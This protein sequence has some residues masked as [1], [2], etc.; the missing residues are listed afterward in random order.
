MKIRIIDI[1]KI[2]GFKIGNAENIDKGTGCTVVICEDG[3]VGGVDVR[4]GGPAT[5]ETD[6]LKSENTIN[7]IN[8]VVLS[9]GSAFGLESGSGVMRELANRGIG[10]DTGYGKVPIV[11]GASLFD[12]S[13]GDGSV[14]PDLE[15]GR[16]AVKNA[17]EGKFE[18]GNRGAGTGASVGKFLG[19]ERAMKSGLGTFACG[20]KYVQV[21]A[22]VAVNAMGDIYNGAGNIVAGL[23]TEEGD[24]VYGSIKS[25]KS[26]VHN[27]N[28]TEETAD[29]IADSGLSKDT[30]SY[31]KAEIADAIRS[32][33]S[34]RIKDAAKTV[35]Q[36]V[37][38]RDISEDDGNEPDNIE[39]ITEFYTSDM[40]VTGEYSKEEIKEAQIANRDEND[41]KTDDISSE[42]A[43]NVNLDDLEVDSKSDTEI[44]INDD[45]MGYDISFNTTIACLITNAKMTKSQANKLASILHDAYA[46]AIK[47]VHGTMD[48]DT[49]FVLTTNKAEVNFDAF[50]ALSTDVLQYAIIDSAS[51]SKSAYGLP[52]AC[53]I[54]KK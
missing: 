33:F 53:D 43:P 3:A 22:I 50:A 31:N 15:M 25:L 47:P 11:C 5:R 42:E 16:E 23:R 30:K 13:V 40:M 38:H 9:G 17:Y 54:I 35:E 27:Y 18:H 2:E 37:K 19:M 46:R 34:T 36:S 4:G 48:G 32:A 24:Q 49:I 52:A 21:G 39:S 26:M 14:F 10:F 20:D 8:A 6:L 28:D 12:L 7:S 1:K 51:S 45:D 44:L 29:E 41:Y